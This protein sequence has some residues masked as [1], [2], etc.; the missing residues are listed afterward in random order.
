MMPEDFTWAD[1]IGADAVMGDNKKAKNKKDK[2]R[3]QRGSVMSYDAS[4]VCYFNPTEYSAAMNMGLY[5]GPP[6]EEGVNGADS[7]SKAPAIEPVNPVEEAIIAKRRI[8]T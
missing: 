5:T 4:L 2:N 8:A 6:A 1:T 3:Q 7:K